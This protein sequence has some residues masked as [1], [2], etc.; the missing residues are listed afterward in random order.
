MWGTDVEDMAKPRWRYI[1]A[2]E[3]L[4]QDPAMILKVGPYPNAPVLDLVPLLMLGY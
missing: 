4:P 1:D 3:P 2:G